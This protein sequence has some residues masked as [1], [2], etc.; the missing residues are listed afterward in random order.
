[1]N[2]PPTDT[3]QVN[4]RGYFLGNSFAMNF[5]SY[6]Q[7]WNPHPFPADPPFQLWSQNKSGP[8]Y[9]RVIIDQDNPLSWLLGVG[10]LAVEDVYPKLLAA[11]APKPTA[12]D[13]LRWF[14][15]LHELYIGGYC[16]ENIS[17][18]DPWMY[19]HHHRPGVEG[20]RRKVWALFSMIDSPVT[21][22]NSGV[23]SYYITGVQPDY[24]R[25]DI[26]LLVRQGFNVGRV[27]LSPEVQSDI[28]FETWL[29]TVDVPIP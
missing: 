25:L 22:P 17:L 24:R 21:F 2:H 6:T 29:G 7:D 8:Y 19:R 4:S 3:N 18:L 26:K 1:M 14:R 20:F 16:G 5:H 27:P 10:L 23:D 9:P 13:L 28:N 15:C 12:G 11:R